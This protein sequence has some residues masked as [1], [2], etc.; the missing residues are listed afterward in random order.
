MRAMVDILCESFLQKVR[1]AI[2]KYF[3]VVKPFKSKYNPQAKLAC[4]FVTIEYVARYLQKQLLVSQI[5]NCRGR[6]DVV[7]LPLE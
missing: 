2:P 1:S 5:V 3:G 4:A 6:M 7:E